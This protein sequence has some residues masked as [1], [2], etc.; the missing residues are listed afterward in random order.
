MATP[1]HTKRRST[2][3][4]PTEQDSLLHR[5]PT[6][7]STAIATPRPTHQLSRRRSSN[8]KRWLSTIDIARMTVCMLGVQFTWTVELGYGT[9][10]LLSLGIPKTLTPLVWLAG[11]LSG[12]II[13]PVVGVF[14][15]SLD[16]KLG[17]RRPFILIG[18]VLTVCSMYMVA[19]AKE[20]AQAFV[21]TRSRGGR[22][23]VGDDDDTDV[24]SAV[25]AWTIGLAVVGFYCL[26]F[27]INAVQASCRS[28]IM[29]IPP[30]DQQE[31]GNAWSGWMNNLGSVVGF[32]AGNL[33]LAMYFAPVLGDTQIKI[34]ANLAM[35]FFISCLGICCLSV[36]EV[37][38]KPTEDDNKRS[39]WSTIGNI[40]R[41]FRTLPGEIQR[42]CNVQFFAWMGWFPFLF[43]STTWV[44]E[45]IH[46]YDN[47]HDD[48]GGNPSYPGDDP[49]VTER[50]GSFALLCWAGVAVFSGIL[51]P[52][53]TPQEIGQER[54]P[55][56]P[57]TLKNIWTM[58]LVWFAVCMGATWFVDDLWAAT[59][60]IALC[61]VP[62]AV[63]MWVPFAMVGEI[64]SDMKDRI[65]EEE[66]E[67]EEE[68][69]GGEG[70]GY[71]A[72][73]K[74]GRFGSHDSPEDH[75]RS[76]DLG[77][78]QGD[79]NG[80]SSTR[81]NGGN[82]S[83]LTATDDMDIEETQPKQTH[84]L[85]PRQRQKGP[86]LDAGLVLGVHNMY[87]VFPQF[88]DAIIASCLFAVI[89]NAARPDQPSDP[90]LPPPTTPPPPGSGDLGWMHW[91]AAK[92]PEP[93]G[94]VLRF[95]GIMA[96]VAAYLSRR[97]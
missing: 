63:A 5:P 77:T 83:L 43:Y 19:Y 93:V 33:N 62:W 75:D 81:G 61:G 69:D 8:F 41:A 59:A 25:K 68:E 47:S 71:G 56:N 70:S 14:S 27:S 78:V 45:I 10:Y 90:T 37:P 13:Q 80:N 23:T 17:R 84:P 49:T 91:A 18:A 9:P 74:G 11:P 35:I 21:G 20:I 34:L 65:M 32:F 31:V 1:Q 53:L 72:V 12:L 94:W 28:L 6:T 60:V 3:F 82:G 85:L 88:V 57:F 97:L 50:A 2:S 46:R 58:S 73:I 38:Y 55:K 7:T 42:I 30:T 48:E 15:D 4:G 39:V 51:I 87:I 24:E 54:W 22:A 16:W 26:D 79:E 86:Q 29:D 52:K 66:A 89:G 40:W 95:G 76:S 36:K 92:D 96:L 64:I 67:D 44:G